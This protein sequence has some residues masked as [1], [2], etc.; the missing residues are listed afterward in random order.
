MRVHSLTFDYYLWGRIMSKVIP[1]S[2]ILAIFLHVP[3]RSFF[4]T[5]IS[6]EKCLPRPQH[7]DTET[8]FLSLFLLLL[9]VFFFFFVVENV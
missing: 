4:E 6:T 3:S 1:F 2:R 9:L 8:L 5:H 7:M